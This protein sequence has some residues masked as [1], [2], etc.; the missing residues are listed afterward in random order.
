M[1]NALQKLSHEFDLIFIDG[2]PALASIG[3][4]ILAASQIL[5]IPMRPTMIDCASTAHLLNVL[6]TYTQQHNVELGPYRLIKILTNGGIDTPNSTDQLI[7]SILNDTFQDS[8]FKNHM[9][10]SAEITSALGNVSQRLRNNQS[11]PL[12]PN[13]GNV[14]SSI[15][16]PSTTNC[17]T[18]F[19]PPTNQLSPPQALSELPMNFKEQLEQ[20]TKAALESASDPANPSH[21]PAPPFAT[22]AQEIVSEIVPGQCRPWTFHDRTAD[23]LTPATCRDL[24]QSIQEEGQ[25]QIPI[26]LRTIDEPSLRYEII[27]GVRR[28]WCVSHLIRHGHP[29]IKLLGVVRNQLS[30]EDAFRLG[31]LENRNRQDISAWERATAYANA[32]PTIYSSWAQL[33]EKLQITRQ[34]I[35]RYKALIDLPPLVRAA[36]ASPHDINTRQA[37]TL[38]RALK[39]SASQDTVLKRA[40]LLRAKQQRLSANS[41]PPLSAQEVTHRLTRPAA[42]STQSQ[43][44]I[45][46]SPDKKIIATVRS[47]TRK[48]GPQTQ[49]TFTAHPE[50]LT[51]LNDLIEKLE[52]HT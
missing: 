25:N 45:F 19:S 5:I 42:Q 35:M 36:Y 15:S 14:V 27:A 9:I 34:G 38:Q 47:R 26:I 2:P 33:A 16:T 6:L 52:A 29:T 8:I 31:D 43:D 17:T 3:L 7:R 10:Q 28:H 13:T 1:R 12:K 37:E 32:I 24:L 51:L 50:S 22:Y 4:S 44:Q 40:A 11:R 18:T 49:V 39:N 30:D 46:L 21:A 23:N 48:D 20:T 41:K